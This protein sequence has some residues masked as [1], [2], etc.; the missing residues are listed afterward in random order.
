[1]GNS[2]YGYRW[3]KNAL[4]PEKHKQKMQGGRRF[5]VAYKD[6]RTAGRLQGLFMASTNLSA[7]VPCGTLPPCRE[8]IKPWKNTVKKPVSGHRVTRCAVLQE[9][10]GMIFAAKL[11]GQRIR[12]I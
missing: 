3:R 11:Y 12:F 7:G 10:G 1:M 6:P 9:T 5:S 8:I 4:M 2:C